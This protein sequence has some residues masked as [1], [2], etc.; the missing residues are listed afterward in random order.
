[1]KNALLLVLLFGLALVWSAPGFAAPAKAKA[2]QESAQK[3]IDINTASKEELQSLPGIGPALAQRI[4]DDRK[5][6]GPYSKVDDLAR[7]KG[8]GP[9]MLA[10]IRHRLSVGPAKDGK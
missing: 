1:M 9:K 8:I 6:N 2:D 10:K 5:Q 3:V 4:L 7:V